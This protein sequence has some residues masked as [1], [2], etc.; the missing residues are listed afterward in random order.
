M[1]P[2]SYSILPFFTL[3]SLFS[4][5]SLPFS[6]RKSNKSSA[7]HFH[8]SHFFVYKSSSAN[9]CRYLHFSVGTDL[10]ITFF[11]PCKIVGLD[12]SWCCKSSSMHIFVCAFFLQFSSADFHSQ[13]FVCISSTV[14][15]LPNLTIPD[16]PE[17]SGRWSGGFSQ[18][19][20]T[21]A[22]TDP[23]SIVSGGVGG[24]QARIQ[25]GQ[26]GRPSFPGS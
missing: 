15:L 12:I 22:L 23:R 4:S 25:R 6:G 1:L 10:R 16:L 21:P 20:L 3:S 11:R 26:P 24:T 2:N 19:R 5:T 18:G 7:W 14:C 9:L 8:V 13:F 17:L